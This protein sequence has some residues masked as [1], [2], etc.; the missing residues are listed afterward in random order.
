MALIRKEIL[1]IKEDVKYTRKTVDKLLERLDKHYKYLSD[2]NSSLGL[3]DLS[4]G[5]SNDY[6]KAIK[7]KATYI[8]IGS[9]IFGNR[10]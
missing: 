3:K 1:E 10:S 2:V 7:Y 4:A 8:R 5:M 6:I 9:S